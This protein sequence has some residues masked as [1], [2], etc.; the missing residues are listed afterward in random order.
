MVYLLPDVTI[1]ELLFKSKFTYSLLDTGVNPST[2]ANSVPLVPSPSYIFNVT[3]DSF[4]GKLMQAF[5]VASS[6]LSIIGSVASLAG[7]PLGFLGLAEGGTV[8]NKGGKLSYA[9]IPKFARG[10][11]YMVPAG[12]SNDSGLIRVQSG[13]RVDVTPSNQ[14]P[15]LG[16]ALDEIKQAIMA[17]NMN[18]AKRGGD[19]V[20]VVVRDT[21]QAVERSKRVEVRQTK[22]GFKYD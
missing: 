12:Y 8:I 17:G 6:V 20:V 4:V 14:V 11:S 21:E 3:A 13:E 2:V 15:M 19:K 5:D 22:G 1:M 10:G 18:S 9:P 7:S 16:K